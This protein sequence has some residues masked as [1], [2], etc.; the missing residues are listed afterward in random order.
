[1]YLGDEPEVETND[2]FMTPIK[3]KNVLKVKY[4]A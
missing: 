4:F 2:A 1:M 3:K